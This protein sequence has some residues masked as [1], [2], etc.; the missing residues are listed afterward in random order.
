MFVFAVRCRSLRAA[1]SNF[2]HLKGL[3]PQTSSP[4]AVRLQITSPWAVR[5]QMRPMSAVFLDTRFDN[6]N[7]TESQFF[8]TER[9]CRNQHSL[10]CSILSMTGLL[11]G[12]SLMLQ[13]ERVCRNQHSFFCSILSMTGLLVGSSLMLQ[14]VGLRALR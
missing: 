13:H 3:R 12:S 2:L 1:P 5:L 9:V 10:F 6:D 14:H 8:F 11:V 7:P 4:W